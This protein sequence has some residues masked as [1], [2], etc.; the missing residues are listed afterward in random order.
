MRRTAFA[1]PHDDHAHRGSHWLVAGLSVVVILT[2]CRASAAEPRW[3][4]VPQIRREQDSLSVVLPD[5]ESRMPEDHV[6]RSHNVVNWAHETTHGLNSRIRNSLRGD[7]NA[8]YCLDG[9]AV[10]LYEPQMPLSAVARHVPTEF[11]DGVFDLYLVEQLSE[12]ELQPLYI[13]D[14]WSAYLN[15]AECIVQLCESGWELPYDEG[16]D[17]G[18]TVEV[19]QQFAVFATALLMAVNEHDPDYA[20]R[21]ELETFVA[22]QKARTL[23]LAQRAEKLPQLGAGD[24]DAPRI[25]L[26]PQSSGDDTLSDE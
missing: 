25:E 1:L 2:A 17:W 20:Q 18:Y 10:V 26:V 4:E 9:R 13:L 22:W 16:E 14:E 21:S 23:R 12:W 19:A 7:V 11:R 6:Y 15:G 24:A 5:L 8:F 3:H